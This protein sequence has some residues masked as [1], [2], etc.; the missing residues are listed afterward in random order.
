MDEISIK[1]VFPVL[2]FVRIKKAVLLF[3]NVPMN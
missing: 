2:D 3:V 1:G